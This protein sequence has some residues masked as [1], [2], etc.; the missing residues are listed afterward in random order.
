MTYPPELPIGNAN[1]FS[2]REELL[3]AIIAAGILANP[4]TNTKVLGSQELDELGHMAGTEFSWFERSV[5]N[6]YQTLFS[7]C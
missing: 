3:K 5:N 4:K 6:V 1:D 7:D 2:S